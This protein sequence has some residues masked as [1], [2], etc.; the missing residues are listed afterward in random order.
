MPVQKEKQ[1]PKLR[2]A[3]LVFINNAVPGDVA[4][5]QTTKQRKAYYEGTAISFS[6][7]S[8]KRVEPKV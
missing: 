5:V 6:K 7:Y 4:T 3:E 8:E 2:M 1:L